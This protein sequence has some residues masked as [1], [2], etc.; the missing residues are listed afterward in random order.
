FAAG[1]TYLPTRGRDV[2]GKDRRDGSDGVA[3]RLAA[4]PLHARTALSH[5]GHGSGCAA[6]A[7]HTR[8]VAIQSKRCIK[9]S[10]GRPSGRRV[11]QAFRPV[12]AGRPEGLHY[13][14]YAAR[15]TSFST[16]P[17]RM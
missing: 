17:S 7:D 16:W 10:V 8:S 13:E 3:L 1:G 14:C 4:T 11:V 6:A 12:I 9:R 2:S 5:S 15:L